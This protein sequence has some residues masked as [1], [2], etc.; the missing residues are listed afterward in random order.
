MS[1]CSGPLKAWGD[2]MCYSEVHV[3]L[4]MQE[5]TFLTRPCNI[6]TFGTFVFGTEGMGGEQHKLKHHAGPELLTTEDF[7]Y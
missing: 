3:E 6:V 1:Q 2:L 4:F 7:C 5:N